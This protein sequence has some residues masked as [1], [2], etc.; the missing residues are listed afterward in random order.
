MDT[1]LF[2]RRHIALETADDHLDRAERLRRDGLYRSAADELREA[3]Q[4][5][6]HAS[7]QQ[8]RINRL[9]AA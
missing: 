9:N 8:D 6:E 3:A 7:V 1:R 5:L 2:T 4:H